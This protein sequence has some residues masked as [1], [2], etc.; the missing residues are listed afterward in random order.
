MIY[1]VLVAFWVGGA[2]VMASC[3]AICLSHEQVR[4]QF[5][6]LFK[7]Q[8]ASAIAFKLL[9]Y[10]LFW[11][12]VLVSVAAN[13][14]QVQARKAPYRVRF[15][16]RSPPYCGNCG[17]SDATHYAEGHPMP[18]CCSCAHQDGDAAD[19]QAGE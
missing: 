19:P 17:A 1:V 6:Y 8:G 18:V 9:G 4:D 12:A 5:L 15:P 2:V 11:P 14:R 7:D 13:P 16:S 10:V 3:V